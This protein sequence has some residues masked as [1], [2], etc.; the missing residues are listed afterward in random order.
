MSD[1]NSQRFVEAQARDDTW[2]L[3]GSLG[4]PFPLITKPTAL[5]AA[6]DWIRRY[7][8]V[9]KIRHQ[10]SGEIVVVAG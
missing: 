9:T 6:E 2:W 10:P 4:W 7:A 8:C 1:S 3:V 5:P